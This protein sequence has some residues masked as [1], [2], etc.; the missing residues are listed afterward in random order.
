MHKTKNAQSWGRKP[1]VFTE[2]IEL[3]RLF[4]RKTARQHRKNPSWQRNPPLQPSTQAAKPAESP[5][6]L[7][8]P[9]DCSQLP[10]RWL[11]SARRSSESVGPA[12]PED[13]AG[14]GSPTDR[15]GTTP[16]ASFPFL[17]TTSSCIADLR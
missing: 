10:V 16:V 5:L 17:A 1:A 11:A 13:P 6:L 2:L 7:S 12:T 8:V 14:A 3:P 9:R 4:I 15:A